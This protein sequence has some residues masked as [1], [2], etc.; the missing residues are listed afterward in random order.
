MRKLACIAI[1]WLSLRIATALIY[2]IRRTGRAGT[3]M[4]VSAPDA[5][6]GTALTGPQQ[7]IGGAFANGRCGSRPDWHAPALLTRR[8]S[9]IPVHS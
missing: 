7:G 6:C 4:R 3:A 1:Q 5:I 9:Q 8:L 2:S